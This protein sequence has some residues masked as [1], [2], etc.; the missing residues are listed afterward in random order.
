MEQ[1]NY[2]L[3]QIMDEGLKI[4]SKY[5]TLLLKESKLNF[6]M[7]LYNDVFNKDTQ[8]FLKEITTENDG[9]SNQEIPKIEN[10]NEKI[11]SNKK[12]IKKIDKKLK[13]YLY[14]PEHELVQ[15][16]YKIDFL[17]RK[18]NEE[19]IKIFKIKLK[20]INKLIFLENNIVFTQQRSLL[21]ELN[22]LGIL[23]TKLEE[24]N[25]K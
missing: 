14:D 19:E 11:I 2:N 4:I 10:I 13:K 6:E 1:E 22:K 7:I 21:K 17:I 5:D 9:W 18:I 23:N 20:K 25:K 24:L 3:H 12:Q 16:K 8:Q 15:L